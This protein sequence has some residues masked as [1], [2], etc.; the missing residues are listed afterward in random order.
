M[1][2]RDKKFHL[3]AGGIPVALHIHTAS[4]PK[5]QGFFAFFI[6]ENAKKGGSCSTL[7][8]GKK[9]PARPYRATQ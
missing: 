8:L 6:P 1:Y 3:V 9:S 5:S 2:Y 4:H 7:F